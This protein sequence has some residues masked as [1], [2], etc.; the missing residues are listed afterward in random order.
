MFKTDNVLVNTKT[1][2]ILLQFVC[3]NVS[4]SGVVIDGCDRKRSEDFEVFVG[5]VETTLTSGK[6]EF[7]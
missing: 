1:P 7:Q 5:G 6:Y 4:F 3:D 2:P